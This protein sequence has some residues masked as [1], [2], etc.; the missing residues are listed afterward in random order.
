MTRFIS[1]NQ[2]TLLRNG[3][4]YF[5][6]LEAAIDEALSEIHLQTYIF[7][8]D[9]VGKHIAAALARA[10]IRG[11]S[12]YLLLDG[13]GCKDTPKKLRDNLR[14]SGVEVLIYRQKISPWTFKRNRLRRQHRK[15]AVIDGAVAFVGGINIIDDMNVPDHTPPRIDYAVRVEGLLLL[16][17]TASTRRLWRHLAWLHL[18]KKTPEPTFKYHSAGDVKA[19]YVVR[20]N[21]LH[22]RDIESAYL[23]AIRHAH[24][25]IIICHAYFLPGI[26]FRRELI[27]AAKRGVRVVILLQARVEFWLINH[28]TRALYG[29]LLDAGIEIH[30]Y[31]KSLMHSK[32]AVIDRHWATVG[33]SNIDPFSLFLSREANVVVDNS[34]FAS[35]LHEDMHF[36]ITNNAKQVSAKDWAHSSALQR[37]L[38]WV[39]YGLIRLLMGLVGINGKD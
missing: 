38:A 1:G 36:A 37:G 27:R 9:A 34:D 31:H 3:A 29:N 25:E 26:R 7:E 24:Q 28:A 30:E 11:V 10:A 22:R 20:D 4:E 32:V 5:P 21:A 39:S 14:E 15:V 2:V 35:R 23:T 33:S 13:F 18:H 8:D 6:A 19:A 16:Q 12:V 17:I